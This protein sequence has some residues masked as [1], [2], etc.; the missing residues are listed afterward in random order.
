MAIDRGPFFPFGSSVNDEISPDELTLEYIH[1][2]QIIRM[3][4]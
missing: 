1:V 4:A 2:D 3:V